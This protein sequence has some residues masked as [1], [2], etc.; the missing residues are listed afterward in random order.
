VNLKKKYQKEDWSRRP[1]PEAML[2]YAV[3]DSLY[4][5][6]M[7][8]ILEEELKDKGRLSW[9]REECELQSR[10]RS[11]NNHEGPLYLKFKGAGKYDARSLAVLEAVLQFRENV[12]QRRDRPPFKVL[13]NPAI[14]A[15]IEEKPATLKALK[16]IKGIGDR[17]IKTLGRPLIEAIQTALNIPE[18]RLPTYPKNKRRPF[19]PEI[20]KRVKALKEWRQGCAKAWAMDPG[21]ICNNALIQAVATEN[22]KAPADLREIAEMRDWQIQAFG[23]EIC[24]F[25]GKLEKAG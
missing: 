20:S 11:V 9:V 5:I 10:V 17:Q 12:A 19:D 8:R 4:L 7:A 3:M 1:L 18:N 21:F 23:R 6:P 14:I 24:S 2:T 25:L 13:G 16:T 22:P 15:L